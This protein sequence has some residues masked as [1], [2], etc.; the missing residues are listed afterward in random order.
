MFSRLTAEEE[1][2]QPSIFMSSRLTAEELRVWFETGRCSHFAF[3][4]HNINMFTSQ[5]R[6]CITDLTAIQPPSSACLFQCVRIRYFRD[7]WKFSSLPT[8]FVSHM[9]VLGA[10]WLLFSNPGQHRLSPM[11][12]Q[13]TAFRLLSRRLPSAPFDFVCYTPVCS[14][15]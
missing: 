2:P 8:G 4:T 14:S 10:Q 1:L 5:L 9:F 12:F 13:D 3:V 15:C 11:R 6:S 7:F